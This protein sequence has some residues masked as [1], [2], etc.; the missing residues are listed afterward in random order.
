MLLQRVLRL[1]RAGVRIPLSTTSYAQKQPSA[2]HAAPWLRTLS[3]ATHAKS[4]STRADAAT[5]AALVQE[6]KTLCNSMRNDLRAA[7]PAEQIAESWAARVAHWR[8]HDAAPELADELLAGY[9]SAVAIATKQRQ[10]ELARALVAQMRALGLVPTAATVQVLIRSVALELL[11]RP[12]ATSV[13]DV[14]VLVPTSLSGSWERDLLEIVRAEEHPH[15]RKPALERQVFQTQLLDGVETLLDQYEASAAAPRSVLPYNKALHVYADNGVPFTRMLELMVQRSVRPDADTYVALL[16]AARWSELPATLNQLLQSG[17]VDALT[18]ADADVATSSD[19][20]HAIW[21]STMKSVLHSYASRFFDRKEPVSLADVD[22]LKKVFRYAEQQLSRAFPRFQFATAA[23][24]E[25]VYT[26]RAK[27]AATAGLETSVMRA[28]DEYVALAPPDAVLQADAF[29]CALELYPSWQLRILLLPKEEVR[30]RALRRD[31]ARSARVSELERAHNRL[32]DKLLPAATDKLATLSAD[33]TTD[34]ETLE[35]QQRLVAAHTRAE[36]TMLQ[37][38]DRARERKSYQLLIQEQFERADRA[39]LA[40]QEKLLDARVGT[41]GDSGDLDVHVKLM[42]QYMTCANRFEQRLRSRQKEVAPQV[43]RRVFRVVKEATAAFDALDEDENERDQPKLNELF[44]LAIR[45]AVLYWRYD[46]ADK[47]ARRKKAVLQTRVLDARDYELL[48]FRE[49]TDRNIRGAYGLVQEM[50]NAGLAPSK[51]VIH[52][53]VLGVLHKL[54][55]QTA[56]DFSGDLLDGIDD[57]NEE[58]TKRDSDDLL[59]DANDDSTATGEDDEKL[60]SSDSQT[61]EDELLFGDELQFD[62][63][64]DDSAEKL[65]LGSGAP[66]ALVDIASFLQDWYNLHGVR[67]AAKTVVPVLARLLAARDLPEFKRLLQILESMEGGLT[68]ATTVWLE[69]RLE[70]V[71]KSLDDFRLTKRG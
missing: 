38:L 53:I 34:A 62:G 68:P 55:K 25:A 44:H 22:E 29:L 6:L 45:T 65:A 8:A 60:M 59:E 63:D 39:V 18:A 69:K 37:R 51:E 21:T 52:R 56:D 12:V 32:A 17:L 31:V 71:G 35:T 10:F 14:R 1:R 46:E 57:E 27:A 23:Q 50:H 42:E 15:H 36:Q 54:D 28:L 33:P 49:V 20:V 19:A 2:L 30:E 61:I 70:R 47:L 67:P 5:R 66:S 26:L 11:A 40:I 43:M 7:P 13:A 58:S 3:V 48:I 41:N 4:A 24:H 16:Q 64:H 9:E